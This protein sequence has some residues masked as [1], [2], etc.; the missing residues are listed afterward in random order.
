M[1]FVKG[2]IPMHLPNYY[3]YMYMMIKR[4]LKEG[5]VFTTNHTPGM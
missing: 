3:I 2:I 1:Y 4:K 5:M